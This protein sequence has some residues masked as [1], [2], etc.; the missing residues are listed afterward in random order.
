[1]EA[2]DIRAGDLIFTQRLN[3]RRRTW[4]R[5]LKVETPK[6]GVRRIF[7]GPRTYTDVFARD[8]IKTHREES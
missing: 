1:M 2:M 5:V 6:P 8:K 4:K 3:E 7:T